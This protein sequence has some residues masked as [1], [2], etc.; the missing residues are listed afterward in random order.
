MTEHHSDTEETMVEV[1]V[2]SPGALLKAAREE[3]KLVPADIAKQLRLSVQWIEDLEND[4][5]DHRTAL[6]Y[7]RGYLRSYARLV[8]LSS[9]AIM[10]AFAT[11]NLED[12]FTHRKNTEDKVLFQ[13]AS[14]VISKS[15]RVI[16]LRFVRRVSVLAILILVMLT[17]LWWQGQRKHQIDQVP[18]LSIQSQVVT[19]SNPSSISTSDKP[20]QAS[21]TKSA[22]G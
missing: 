7:I 18:T 21:A 13:P 11:L 4:S 3:K 1:N 2:L 5:Y 8:G 6:I 14:S 17:A 19:T 15:T 9:E 20:V 16:N 12:Q 10:A 22:A